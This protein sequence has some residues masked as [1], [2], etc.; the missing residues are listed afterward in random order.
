MI[1]EHLAAR[2]GMH[3]IARIGLE[4]YRKVTADTIKNMIAVLDRHSEVRIRFPCG[5]GLTKVHLDHLSRSIS[6]ARMLNLGYRAL[7]GNYDWF[8]IFTAQNIESKSTIDDPASIADQINKAI[9]NASREIYE[10]LE[11][12]DAIN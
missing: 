11:K 5:L 4:R 3:V 8:F 7:K 1:L 6:D 9:P 2:H 12:H 10:Y